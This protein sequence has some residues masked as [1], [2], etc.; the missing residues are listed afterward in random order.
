M[1]VS[2]ILS[3]EEAALYVRRSPSFL[4]KRRCT[5]GGPT[6]VRIGRRIGYMIDDLDDWLLA[7]RRRSTSDPGAHQQNG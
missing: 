4:N 7:Q 5:G 6:F 2:R 1:K 3:N